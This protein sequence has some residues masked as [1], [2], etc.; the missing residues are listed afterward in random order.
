[1]ARGLFGATHLY[2]LGRGTTPRA[3]GP[4]HGTAMWGAPLWGDSGDSMES[5]TLEHHTIHYQRNTHL[6]SVNRRIKRWRDTW[7]KF[8]ISH[9]FPAVQE[10]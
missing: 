3:E 10:E 9:A 6:S 5:H 2:L 4:H 7:D 8:L 1:V